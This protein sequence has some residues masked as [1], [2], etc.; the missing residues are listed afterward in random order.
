VAADTA[1]EP[2]P[3]DSTKLFKGR[4]YMTVI[5]RSDV[6]RGAMQ[7]EVKRLLIERGARVYG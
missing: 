7:E 5:A 1:S 6:E 4:L 3:E 2:I